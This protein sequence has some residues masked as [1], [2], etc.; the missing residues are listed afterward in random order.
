[1][2]GPI[3]M[4]LG[5]EDNPIRPFWGKFIK[6]SYEMTLSLRDYFEVSLF[7]LFHCSVILLPLGSFQSFDHCGL[8]WVNVDFFIPW[9][10]PGRPVIVFW[11]EKVIRP[12]RVTLVV[13]DDL[14]A[15]GFHFLNKMVKVSLF[16]VTGGE[17]FLGYQ[18][19]VKGLNISFLQ[20]AI[21]YAYI[22]NLSSELWSP[23]VP[24]A[25]SCYV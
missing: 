13:K 21:M 1:M 12:T 16:R 7:T 6:C 22:L 20:P 17:G 2:H 9:V 23:W 25:G 3:Y 18:D 4:V 10:S 5:T 24:V 15:W 14:C 11:W 8:W 19:Q